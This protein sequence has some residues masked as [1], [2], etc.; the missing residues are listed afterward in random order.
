MTARPLPRLISWVMAACLSA[1]L[2][3]FAAAQTQTFPGYDPQDP[4]GSAAKELWRRIE[5]QCGPLNGPVRLGTASRPW[6]ENAF[7][8]DQGN[9]IMQ[10]VHAAFS[11]LDGVRMAPFV[12]IGPVLNISD[13]GIL[14]STLAG[15]AREQ[16]SKIEIEIR[17]TGQRVGPATRLLLSVHGWNGYESCS[18][19]LDP[20]TIPEEFVGEIYRRT[21]HIFDEVASAVWEQSLDTSNTLVLSATMLN[22]APVNPSWLEFFSNRMRKA[23]SN[24]NEEEKSSRIRAP[25]QVAFAMLHDASLDQE[26]RWTASVTVEP[27]HNGF[28]ISVTASRHNTTPVFSGGLIAFDDLPAATQWAA[29]G[30][31]GKRPSAVPALS[32]TPLRIEG[33]VEPSRG[34]QQYA[35]ALTRES[36]VEVDIPATSLRG[37]GPGAGQRLLVEVFAPGHPSFKTIHIP[38]PS[39][40]HLRRYRLGP[41]QY[42]IRVA[43]TGPTR[44]EYQLRA[45]AVDTGTMLQPEA[46]GRLI[47]RFQDWYAS[48]VENPQTGTRTCYAYT[49]ATEAGPLNW[50]EQ[51]PFILLSA[52][53]EGSGEIQHLI[54][55]KRYYREGTV[56]AIVKEGGVP[57]VLNASATATGNFIRPVKEGSNGQPILDMDAIAG[58]NKGTTLEINGTTPDGRPAHVI[59]SLQGYR[60]AVNAMSLECGRRDLAN[61]LV[62]K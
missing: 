23:L 41:G 32:E 53:S 11:R 62:W 55:D 51:A 38:N 12:D 30:A 29:L 24:Q 57:R 25:R 33:K 16:L 36:Y 44:L 14:D 26:K 58:Y 45:R 49:A 9:N 27:R 50:R 48:V 22:G 28:R 52:Q 47:R 34:L 40:P 46:P 20:F 42:T 39:R 59:Y 5:K 54:E 13:T 10:Q 35:F 1:A 8:K 60:A 4:I 15:N 19:S 21:D 6:P 3:A 2:P 43:N 56:E 17:A 31:G 37:A 61:A 18:P 7:S